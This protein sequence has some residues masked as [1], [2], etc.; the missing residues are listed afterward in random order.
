MW[1]LRRSVVKQSAQTCRCVRAGDNDNSNGN[2]SLAW[3]IS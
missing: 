2:V 1:T 3:T